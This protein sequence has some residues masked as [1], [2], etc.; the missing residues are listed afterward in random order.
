MN[1]SKAGGGHVLLK[2]SLFLCCK[3]SC[4]YAHLLAFTSEKH[5]ASL[6]ILGQVSKHIAVNLMVFSYI[7]HQECNAVIVEIT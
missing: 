7:K 6:A 2:T 5:L 4:S 3:S 1:G